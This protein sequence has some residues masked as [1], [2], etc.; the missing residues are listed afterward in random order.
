MRTKKEFYTQNAE[1]I[2]RCQ[3][4]TIKQ[5]LL[6]IYKQ[7]ERGNV[8][9]EMKTLIK[10]HSR[11]INKYDLGGKHKYD[12]ILL[13]ETYKNTKCKELAL[14]NLTNTLNNKGL[15][16]YFLTEHEAKEKNWSEKGPGKTC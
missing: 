2:T 6:H 12:T 3:R 1:Y 16:S 7:I 5:D 8:D 15:F 4:D 9:K 10:Q 13:L 14:A 11:L